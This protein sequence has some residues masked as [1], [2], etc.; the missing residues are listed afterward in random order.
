MSLGSGCPELEST[1]LRRWNDRTPDPWWCVY[2][3]KT[4]FRFEPSSP[5]I[6]FRRRA[7]GEVMLA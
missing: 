3:R 4:R 1:K 7:P 5:E 2:K 6:G